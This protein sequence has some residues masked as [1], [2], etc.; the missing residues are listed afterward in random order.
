MKPLSF[1]GL[2]AGIC[3]FSSLAYGAEGD[4]QSM[5]LPETEPA[6]NRVERYYQDFSDKFDFGAANFMTGM[7]EIII[8]PVDGFKKKKKIFPRIG[9]AFVGLGTGVITGTLDTLGGAGN[10]VTSPVPQFRIPLPKGGV[11]L[12]RMTGRP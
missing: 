6:P 8:Q 3:I 11:N 5:Q 10:L 2:I 9:S 1:L 12:Q 7:S 4:P